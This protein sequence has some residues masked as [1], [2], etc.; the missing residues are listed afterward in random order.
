[1]FRRGGFWGTFSCP[2]S[3]GNSWAT[4]TPLS[5]PE[6]FSLDSGPW[7]SDYAD[8]GLCPVCGTLCVRMGHAVRTRSPRTRA[9]VRRDIRVETCAVDIDECVTHNC[10]NGARCIDGV[11]RYSC[12]CTPGWEGAL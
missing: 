5:C 10:Q 6:C 1:V 7:C 2:I 9:N 4:Q 8:P 11:A 3:P 12:E